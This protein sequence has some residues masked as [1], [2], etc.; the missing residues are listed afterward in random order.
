[1]ADRPQ[2]RTRTPANQRALSHLPSDWNS[3][4]YPPLTSLAL[5]ALDQNPGTGPEIE[6]QVLAWARNPPWTAQE[7]EDWLVEYPEDAEAADPEAEYAVRRRD[8]LAKLDP[9]QPP[10]RAAQRL[11]QAILERWEA[12]SLEPREPATQ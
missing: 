10:A 7:V 11:L 3:G 12:R 5:W 1:M 6:N 4:L 8:L 9:D 2:S